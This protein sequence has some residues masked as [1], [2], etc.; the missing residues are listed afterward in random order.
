MAGGRGAAAALRATRSLA[1][2]VLMVVVPALAACGGTNRVAASG[3]AS[4]AQSSSIASASAGARRHTGGTAP[5]ESGS[6]VALGGTPSAAATSAWLRL[7][8]NSG[9]PGTV[10]TL[11]GYLAADA[12][13]PPTGPAAQTGIICWDGC[14]G[15]L[16]ISPIWHWTGAAAQGTSGGGGTA[17][18][19]RASGS[20]PVAAPTFETTFTVPAIP[21]LSAAG[22]QPLTPG[23]YA[24]GIQ[25]VGRTPPG[26]ALAG[27]Q[28]TANF[29]LTGPAPALPLQC[30]PGA[31][32][33]HLA[34][35]PASAA[36]GTEV[37]VTGW[38]PLISGSTLG[39]Q[40]VLS[41]G[42]VTLAAVS[43]DASGALS[44]TFAVPYAVGS[45]ELAPGPHTLSLQYTFYALLKGRPATVRTVS[46]AA[47]TLTA[48]PPPLWSSLGPVRPLWIRASQRVTGAVVASAS[49]TSGA[50]A[51]CASDGG[52]RW[53]SDGGGTWASLPTSAAVSVAAGT[54]YVFQPVPRGQAPVPA[55]ASAVPDPDHPGVFYATFDLVA[56][57][58]DCAPPYI[59]VGYVTTDSGAHWRTVPPPAG[60][61][62]GDFGGFQVHGDTVQALFST[63]NLPRAGQSPHMAVMQTTDGGATWTAAP[64]GCPASG[65]CVRLGARAS[66]INAC[67]AEIGRS[68]LSST[69]GGSTWRALRTIDE[70]SNTATEVGAIGPS[71]LLLLGG[72][73]PIPDG[74]SSSVP[75]QVSR[76]SGA[77]WSVVALPPLPGPAAAQEGAGVLPL[78]LLPDGAIAAADGTSVQLLVPGASSWCPASGVT[79]PRGAAGFA[80]AGGSYW[81]TRVAPPTGGADL[82][83]PGSVP[84]ST[85]RC[86]G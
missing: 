77:T 59:A 3:H 26:C 56:A 1:A 70:C 40:L 35:R 68:V 64:L 39:Y 72:G 74:Q 5:G 79:L 84:L 7:S 65:P 76:D 42:N 22:P 15:G 78:A 37:T 9:P 63:G 14:A 43:Q 49:A 24:V 41:S 62:L 54:K 38:A 20:P 47:A 66:H 34:L 18:A 11:T 44:G 52:I 58:C 75:L 6:G 80:V 82:V 4:W 83:Q 27:P 12:G 2:G 29:H 19:T 81:W 30:A 36:P 16:N 71:T 21:W 48:D 17:P 73:L 31:P 23:T 55:C 86:A 10:V 51:V 60:F 45:T 32:C 69:D 57:P 85:L 61:T 28:A 46:V 67:M 50:V 53:T 25:C 33:A 8:P 13:T